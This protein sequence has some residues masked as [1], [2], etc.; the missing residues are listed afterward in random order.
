MAEWKAREMGS[1]DQR[2]AGSGVACP[3]PAALC[4]EERMDPVGAELR[5]TDAVSDVANQ[6]TPSVTAW[7]SVA[8]AA[9]PRLARREAPSPSACGRGRPALAL[10][11]E[12]V[13]SGELHT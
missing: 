9:R 10:P 5:E 4:S 7:A 12:A 2:P 8:C 11:G 6:G 3:W 1:R 13:L